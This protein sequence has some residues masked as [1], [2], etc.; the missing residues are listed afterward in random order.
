MPTRPASCNRRAEVLGKT[1]DARY[2]EILANEVKEAWQRE[3]VT[4]TGRVGENTQTAYALAL[5]FD[6]L[7]EYLRLEAASRLAADVAIHDTHLTTGFVGTPYLC[8]A[9]SANGQMGTAFK[10][11]NQDTYPSWLYPVKQGATTIW[12][13]WDGLKPDGT[14]Q[15][16][17]MNSFNHYAY[18]AIGDWM[19]RFVAGIDTAPDGPGYKHVLIQPHPGG[20]LTNVTAK[21]ET[22]YGPVK[23][24]WKLDGGGMSLDV[25]VPP[26]THATIRLPGAILEGVTE[27]GGPAEKAAGVKAARQDGGA[28]IVETGSGNYTFRFAS[29]P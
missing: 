9:L 27:G 13:R 7:P 4:Q 26:N 12:E 3:F 20:G 10:L 28:V 2:Y 19:Y 1:D 14:F 22:M 17:G 18:G 29:R 11:L 6:L 5:E 24:A 16:P 8:P 15:D 21:L 23:S 25:G